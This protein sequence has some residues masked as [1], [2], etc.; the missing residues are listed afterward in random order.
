M[1]LILKISACLCFCAVLFFGEKISA[2]TFRPV[3]ATI[4]EQEVQFGLAN[5]VY[6]HFENLLG[7]TLNLKWRRLEISK[8]NDWGTALCDYGTCYVGIP[9]SGKMNPLPPTEN[10]YLKLLVQPNQTP[11]TAWIWFRVWRVEDENDFVDVYF[12]IKTPG[13]L[14]TET[15]ENQSFEMFPNPTSGDFFVKNRTGETQQI[16]LRDVFGRVVFSAEIFAGEEKT[17]PSAGFSAGQYFLENGKTAQ[18]VLI[19]K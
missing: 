9:S 17:V 6:L 12:S 11:G 15:P 2:Q 5:E 4:L 3:E 16:R 19:L 14:A 13:T 10:A 7:D 1:N 18:R 8:P